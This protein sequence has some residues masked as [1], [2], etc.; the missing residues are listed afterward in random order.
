VSAIKVQNIAGCRPKKVPGEVWTSGKRG[1]ITQYRRVWIMKKLF[2]AM[3][4]TVFALGLLLAASA[5]WAASERFEDYD[6]NKDGKISKEEFLQHFKDKK[7]GEARFKSMDKDSSGFCTID[8]WNTTC[9]IGA[10][11]GEIIGLYPSPVDEN[12]QPVTFTD[13]DTNKDGKVSKEEFL[14]PFK[15]KA[16]GERRWSVLMKNRETQPMTVDEFN[17]PAKKK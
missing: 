2:G 10:P 3:V 15:D 1:V 6:T 12:N 17:L 11:R 14:A 5:A 4:A 13:L 7:E 16:E 9:V 8:E